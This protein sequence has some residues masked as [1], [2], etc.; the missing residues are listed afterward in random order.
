MQEAAE[1]N[2]ARD[3]QVDF[4]TEASGLPMKTVEKLLPQLRDST[5]IRYDTIKKSYSFWPISADPGK[6]ERILSRRLEGIHFDFQELQNLNTEVIHQFKYGNLPLNL[7]WG[8]PDDW[9]AEQQLLTREFFIVEHLRELAQPYTL[10]PRGID[11][12]KRGLVVWLL[13]QSE[14][15]IQWY[16]ENAGAILDRAM[17]SDSRPPLLLVLPQ[18]PSPDLFTAFLR[19]QALQAMSQLERTDVGGA[20]YDHENQRTRRTLAG[21]LVRIIGDP[22]NYLDA[23]RDGAT[24]VA[25]QAFR[26]AIL[27]QPTSSLRRALTAAYQTAYSTAPREFFNQ[28]RATSQGSNR[29]RDAVKLVAGVLLMGQ[30][31]NLPSAVRTVPVASD[32]TS[33]YLV[34]KWGLL[35][36]EYLLQ[37][38]TDA[39][40]KAA[41]NLLETAFAPGKKEVPAARPLAQLLNAPNGYD[42]NTAILLFAAWYGYHIHDL[43]LRQAGRAAKHDLLSSYLQKG[44]KEFIQ[45]LHLNSI[46]LARRDA[47]EARAGR[48]ILPHAL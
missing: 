15:D 35:S 7:S 42:Y 23:P 41:W 36:G 5:V 19:S 18:M 24:I 8:H 31:Q 44:A 30:G 29:L 9:A 25:P 22:D 40:V 37:R 34:Q 46:A 11:E 47:D 6:L 2:L 4:L 45:N 14:D 12:G 16:R 28:Y 17:D 27:G 13:A 20:L 21:E 26:S 38:P 48:T 32:L 10:T 39:R 43:E 1:L 33:K 3:R